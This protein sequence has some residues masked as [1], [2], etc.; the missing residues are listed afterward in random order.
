V[1]NPDYG[2]KD[3]TAVAPGEKEV[4]IYHTNA[5]RVERAGLAKAFHDESEPWEERSDLTVVSPAIVS[6]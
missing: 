6:V 2:S 4:T 5:I 3:K 1:P